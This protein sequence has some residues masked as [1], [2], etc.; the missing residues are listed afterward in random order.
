MSV[1]L[2]M[3]WNILST[4][5]DG[6]FSTVYKASNATKHAAALKEMKTSYSEFER[7]VDA[8]YRA[9]H[10][11]V[12][13]LLGAFPFESCHYIAMELADCDMHSK[14]SMKKRFAEA[15]AFHIVQQVLAAMYHI[16]TVGLAHNDIKL[17]NVL[18][19]GTDEAS[20]LAKLCDFG[21]AMPVSQYRSGIM[22]GTFAYS[23]PEVRSNVA[24]DARLSDLFALGMVWFAAISGV[25]PFDNSESGIM[26]FQKM[27][28]REASGIY[29][30]TT[31]LLQY[32][33]VPVSLS[34]LTT[35]R[36][37][38]M[39]MFQPRRRVYEVLTLK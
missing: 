34:R 35:T 24:H 29:T 26:L 7:E 9:R 1:P 12:I 27:M 36:L 11:H 10:P 39:L 25:L 37:D 33:G 15:S 4:M 22:L 8:M 23:S 5:G 13:E 18:L 14:L 32:C 31:K 3:D 38:A 2:N 30:K 21:Q 17:E 19:F 16:H 6:S 20:A 28:K